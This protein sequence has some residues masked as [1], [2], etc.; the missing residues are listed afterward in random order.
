M[1]LRRAQ[2]RGPTH[3]KRKEKKRESCEGGGGCFS[4]GQQRAASKGGSEIKIMSKE[5][6]NGVRHLA[7]SSS[8]KLSNKP[9]WMEHKQVSFSLSL[10]CVCMFIVEFFL[11]ETSRRR[12]IPVWMSPQRAGHHTVKKRMGPLSTLVCCYLLA[13]LTVDRRGRKL[14]L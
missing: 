1:C 4:D 3:K 2:R 7:S 14:N 9:V 8:G 6:A 11:K 10:S 5:K 12:I 13:R